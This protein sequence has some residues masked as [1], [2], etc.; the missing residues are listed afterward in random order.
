[1]S[2]NLLL[3]PITCLTQTTNFRSAEGGKRTAVNHLTTI[4]LDTAAIIEF[5]SFINHKSLTFIVEVMG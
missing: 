4:F 1:M 5:I 3:P 2:H